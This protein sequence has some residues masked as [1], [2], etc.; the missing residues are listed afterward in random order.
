METVGKETIFDR[1]CRWNFK[2][3]S[4]DLK[5]MDFVNIWTKMD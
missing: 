1:E 5:E 2:N 3:S 4:M